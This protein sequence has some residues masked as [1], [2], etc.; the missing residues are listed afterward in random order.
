MVLNSASPSTHSLFSLPLAISRGPTASKKE[1]YLCFPSLGLSASVSWCDW[2]SYHAEL[3]HE[4]SSQW[5]RRQ[6]KSWETH[7]KICT[8]NAEL[9]NTNGRVLYGCIAIRSFSPWSITKTTQVR[10]AD[11]VL[12][13]RTTDKKAVT[14]DDP[15]TLLD[16]WYAGTADCPVGQFQA[17]GKSQHVLACRF[18]A[19][20]IVCKMIGQRST[21]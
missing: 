10:P 21:K 2:C 14:Q 3:S 16:N 18:A 5:C 12:F 9:L 20:T 8:T 17:H 11:V 4:R 15:T 19:L 7:V 13:F 6:G 1:T